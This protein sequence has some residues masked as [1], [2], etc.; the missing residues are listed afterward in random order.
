[1]EIDNTAIEDLDGAA[2]AGISGDGTWRF[3]T[4]EPDTTDPQI[5][6]LSPT[7]GALDIAID[8]IWTITFTEDVVFDI[9]SIVL[10]ENGGSAVETFDVGN[11][12]AGLTLNGATGHHQPE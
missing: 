12:P 3:T 1:V 10:R 4:G 6:T 11:P 2:F 9:G 8:T 7:H 5:Q